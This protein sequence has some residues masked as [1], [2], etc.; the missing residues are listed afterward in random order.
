MSERCII[1]FDKTAA[2]WVVVAYASGDA[3]MIDVVESG[4][5]PHLIT[6]SLISHV[7]EALVKE[8]DALVKHTTDAIEIEEIRR[9]KLPKLF[10]ITSSDGPIFLPRTMSIR[11]CG[12]KSNHGLNYIM[13]PVEFANFAEMEQSETKK[14]I[15]LYT[16][17][18]YPSVPIWW[19]SV[20]RKLKQDRTLDNCFGRRVILYDPLGPELVKKG[21]AFTP[22][23]TVFDL[24]RI[25][26]ERMYADS[27]LMSRWDILAQVHD[28]VTSQAIINNWKQ[29]A[30]DCIKIGLDYMNS[31][32]EYSGRSFRIGTD[33]KIG[34]TWGEH[35]MEKVALTKDID[36]LSSDLKKAW[37]RT[38]A[39]QKD[40]A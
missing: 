22:Q 19:E 15:H 30:K 31:E 36:K 40:A 21:V 34:P 14:V 17:T 10:T 32:C 29:L 9:K 37:S 11:Q 12:K 8:E 38:N 7:P 4:K 33:L 1:E 27:D 6:G 26:M 5:D 24:T 3:R 20:K 35:G 18:A 25:G 13:G 16:R 39:A 23:S 28:S 2:E